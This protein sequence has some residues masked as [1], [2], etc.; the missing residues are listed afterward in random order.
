MAQLLTYELA[1]LV[2]RTFPAVRATITED[3]VRRYCRAI[4]RRWDG[5]VP[6]SFLA[7]LGADQAVDTGCSD[8][9]AG[10]P[11]LP[12][13]PLPAERRI[14][15]G[16][17]WEFGRRPQLGETLVLQARL[18]SLEQREGRRGPV[19]L[20]IVEVTYT[21]LQGEWVATQ[22]STCVHR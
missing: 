20:S 2:G 15:T 11:Q 16:V 19:L 9:L 12:P 6:W 7:H 21:D 5:T 3:G 22:R 13:L 17:A 14:L 18:A 4:G 1:T 8:G 10:R